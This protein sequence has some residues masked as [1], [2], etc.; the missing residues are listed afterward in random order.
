MG[1]SRCGSPTT[2]RC[3]WLLSL[4]GAATDRLL[5]RIAAGIDAAV[6]EVVAFWGTDWSH[7]IFVV[8]AGSDEQFHAAA[9]GGLASQWA[10]IAA[11]TVVDRVDPARRT[12]VGQRIVFAPGAAHMSPAALRIVL[13]HELFHYAARADTALDAPR[14]LAEG[15]AD[16]VARPKTRRPRMRCLWRCRYRRTPTWTLR[17]HSARWHMT[18]RGGSLGSSRPPTVPPSCVSFIWPLVVSDTSTWL[19]PPTTSSALTPLACSRAG[20]GG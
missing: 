7:D 14:W 11:I 17:G 18:A 3:G 6:D 4:G 15:V 8:A 5:S 10:D 13:G 1:L 19:P 9:G 16:F 12:V 20:S 2:A